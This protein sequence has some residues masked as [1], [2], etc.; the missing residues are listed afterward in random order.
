MRIKLLAAVSV[1]VLAAL[2][3]A[4]GAWAGHTPAPAGQVVAAEAHAGDGDGTV[5]K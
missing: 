4:A 1:A 3:F 5:V 2:G